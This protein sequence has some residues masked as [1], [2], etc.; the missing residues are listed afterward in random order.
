LLVGMFGAVVFSGIHIGAWNFNFP[1]NIE[2][3]LWRGASIYAT[4]VRLK[5]LV[6]VRKRRPLGRD[7][8]HNEN[9]SRKR[10]GSA[11]APRKGDPSKN[12]DIHN[13][14]EHLLTA[15]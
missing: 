9:G 13:N 10:Q 12:E 6:T 3:K 7:W 15:P 14:Q 5:A 8:L 1:S 11:N 2:M 4:A